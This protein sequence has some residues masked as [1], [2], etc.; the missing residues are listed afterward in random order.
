MQVPQLF[1]ID[2]VF[3]GV[4]IYLLQWILRRRG[5][6]CWSYFFDATDSSGNEYRPAV[7]P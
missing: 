7:E 4:G 2:S 1:A 6:V 5:H 3:V